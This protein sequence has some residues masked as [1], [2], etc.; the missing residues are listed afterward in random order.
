MQ[1]LYKSLTFIRIHSRAIYDE[2]SWIIWVLGKPHTSTL[3]PPQ[4]TCY[5]LPPMAPSGR[6]RQSMFSHE[7]PPVAGNTRDFQVGVWKC[8]LDCCAAKMDHFQSTFAIL[9]ELH[10]NGAFWRSDAAAAAR[11]VMLKP[12]SEALM[13]LG[14]FQSAGHSAAD[15]QNMRAG[16]DR[17]P[18]I[19]R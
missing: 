12:S 4:R 7:I 9:G 2:E 6:T 15:A 1:F 11:Q 5:R 18:P 3:I 16:K 17:W 14:L 8:F 10:R 13:V 19:L